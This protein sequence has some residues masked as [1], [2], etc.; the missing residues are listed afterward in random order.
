M[1]V[2]FAAKVQGSTGLY[3]AGSHFYAPAFLPAPEET[4]LACWHIFKEITIAAMH[5]RY[6]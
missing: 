6:F 5:L 1:P 4:A 3:I 2:T